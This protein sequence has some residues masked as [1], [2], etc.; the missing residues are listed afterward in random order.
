[1]F[2]WNIANVIQSCLET[3]AFIGRQLPDHL[4]R[5]AGDHAIAVGK[6]SGNDGAR[7][8]DRIVA[9]GDFRQD[10]RPHSQ[11]AVPTDPDRF[12]FPLDAQVREVMVRAHESDIR[13]Y[14]GIV[15]DKHAVKSMD[16]AT[17]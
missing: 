14:E 11:P 6:G 5:I 7:A 2:F 9:E 17:G 12:A 13:P 15:A 4:S 1:M 8:H 10:D 3:G 16:I